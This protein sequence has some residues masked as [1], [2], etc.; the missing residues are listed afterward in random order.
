MRFESPSVNRKVSKI[1]LMDEESVSPTTVF[2]FETVFPERSVEYNVNGLP[3]GE[4]SGEQGFF[5]LIPMI[6]AREWKRLKKVLAHMELNSSDTDIQATLGHSNERGETPLHTAAWKAPTKLVLSLLELISLSD[7]KKYLLAL[8]C[9]G[10][11]PLHLACA[12]LDERIEF[13]VIK[14]LLVLAPESLDAKNVNGDTR[15]Y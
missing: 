8:D 15:K 12:N 7:R 3:F 11:T 13:S 2:A 10:N 6:E 9:D 4:D 5:D 1:D 14:N